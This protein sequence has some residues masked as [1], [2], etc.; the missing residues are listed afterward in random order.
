MPD[1]PADVQSL[2]RRLDTIERNQ[3]DAA[4]TS[5]A[6][7]EEIHG[8]RTDRA[9]RA[10]RE[11]RLNERLERIEERIDGVYKIG[12]WFLALFGAAFISLLA[13]FTFRG[14]FFSGLVN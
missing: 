3:S 7:I 4:K 2:F 13:N 1:L 9:V 10:E 12:W 5:T 14:G 8:V 6:I 11:L